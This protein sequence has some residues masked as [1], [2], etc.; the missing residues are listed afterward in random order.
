MVKDT[1]A[2]A[3][4]RG[5]QFVSFLPRRVRPAEQEAARIRLQEI[6]EQE[7]KAF[8]PVPESDFPDDRLA[9]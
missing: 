3:I 5:Q 1:H 6:L 7:G 8:E 9:G 2:K 4:A